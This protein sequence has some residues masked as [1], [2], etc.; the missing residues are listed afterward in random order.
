MRPGLHTPPTHTFHVVAGD[1]QQA[2]S[3]LADE[4]AEFADT[5]VYKLQHTGTS[6]TESL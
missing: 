1:A 6:V 3:E 4:G 5:L 2:F